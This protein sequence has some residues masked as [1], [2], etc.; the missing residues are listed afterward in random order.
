MGNLATKNRFLIFWMENNGFKTGIVMFEKSLSNGK[1]ATGLV[2][3]FCQKSTFF[4]CVFCWEIEPQKIV[5]YILDRKRML[6]R[7]E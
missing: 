4:S 2:H 6:F 5:F 1:F 7:R 3:G